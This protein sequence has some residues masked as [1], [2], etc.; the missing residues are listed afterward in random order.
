MN[1]NNNIYKKSDILNFGNTE[2]KHFIKIFSY[3]SLN[4]HFSFKVFKNNYNQ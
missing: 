2:A 1:S 3:K 4:Q